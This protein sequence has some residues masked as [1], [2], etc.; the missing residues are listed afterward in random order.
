MRKVDLK[1]FFMIEM[2]EIPK[3][4]FTSNSIITISVM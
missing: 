3:K 4:Y 2:S 1:S